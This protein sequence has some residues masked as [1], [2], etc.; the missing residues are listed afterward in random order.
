MRDDKHIRETLTH[1]LAELRAQVANIETGLQQPLDDD[2]AEQA[3]DRA[4]DQALDAVEQSALAEIE[5]IT[6]ALG[7]LEMGTYGTCTAC[8]GAIAPK[9]LEAMP[10][11]GLCIRCAN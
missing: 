4:D 1:R 5:L 7:R 8:G 3:I 6:R 2:F 9:R 10:A 11:A